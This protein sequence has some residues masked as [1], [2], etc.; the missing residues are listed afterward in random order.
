MFTKNNEDPV[1]KR[2][3]VVDDM[4]KQRRLNILRQKV[5]KYNETHDHFHS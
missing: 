5:D 1:K 2:E 3:A 4:R